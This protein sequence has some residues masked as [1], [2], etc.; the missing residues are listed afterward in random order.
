MNPNIREINDI[1]KQ[2]QVIGGSADY[3]NHICQVPQY[4][5]AAADIVKLGIKQKQE[6]KMQNLQNTESEEKNDV[7]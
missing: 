1:M 7:L 5:Q 2:M 4:N 6:Q 3:S